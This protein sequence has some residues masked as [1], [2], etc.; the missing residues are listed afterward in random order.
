MRPLFGVV[1]SGGQTL[2]IRLESGLVLR[3]PNDRG[4]SKYDKVAVFYDHTR[5]RIVSIE[6]HSVNEED[7]EFDEASDEAV[8]V[9]E[10]EED[11][12]P[13]PLEDMDSGALF[14]CFDGEWDPEEGVLREE[15]ESSYE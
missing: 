12:P 13:D 14:P 9:D 4:F 8:L 1:T 10:V 11:E 2:V 7:L 15:G 3:A 6:A 5:N